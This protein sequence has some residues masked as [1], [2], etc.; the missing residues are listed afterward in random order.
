MAEIECPYCGAEDDDCISDLW[1]IEGDDNEHECGSCEKT[2]IINAEVTVNY[3]ANKVDCDDDSHI[4][5]DWGRYDYLGSNKSLW[6]RY[7]DNCDH[8]EIVETAY[9]SDLPQDADK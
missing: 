9:Q 1:E 6:F 7:C 8:R 3:T 4:Y 2:I 5:G